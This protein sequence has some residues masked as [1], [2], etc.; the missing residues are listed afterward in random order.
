MASKPAV[1]LKDNH[2]C[3]HNDKKGRKGC[4]KP[5]PPGLA[6]GGCS[7]EGAF[8]ALGPCADA[9]HLV[10]G[11]A[12]CAGV[13]WETRHT[14]TSFEG[15][16]KTRMGFSTD[17]GEIQVVYGGEKKLFHAIKYAAEHYQPKA[18]FVYET[19]VTALIGD[20]MDAVCAAQEKRLGIP[21]IPVHAAGFVG[22]KNLGGRI[23]LDAAVK[24]LAGTAEPAFTT[25]FDIN[26]IGEYNI[27]GEMWHYTPL[28][29][30]LGIRILSSF[31]GDGR[32]EHMRYAHRAKLNVVVCAKSVEAVCVG[33][34]ER[35]GIPYLSA[36]FYGMYDAA[37]S[38]R[39]ICAAL[40]DADLMTR[41][42][43][44]IAREEANVRE[45]LKP[46]QSRIAGRKVVLNTGGNKAWSLA[47]ALQDIGLTVVATSVRKSGEADRA[48]V[49]ERFGQDIVLMEKPETEQIEVIRSANADILI[50]GGRSLYAALK[51]RIAF[52]DCNQEK[53]ETYCGYEGLVH[54]ASDVADALANPV[55]RLVD[56]PAPWDRIEVAQRVPTEIPLPLKEVA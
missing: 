30:E 54:L 34:Q 23:G 33:M 5:E 44:L 47:G 8:F 22:N 32:V 4:Q 48:K 10:H 2:A 50:A 1:E 25:P 19:C 45:R 7:F 18:I 39:R 24:H 31:S 52:I 43:A 29:E 28:L 42:E 55:F 16:D 11:P 21:V 17:I 37:D 53:H 20:D 27:T 12:T 15:R 26:L 35:F 41:A 9:V 3:E 14:K 46:F 51:R 6:S 56:R 13:S 49:L 36:S 38:I 40:G